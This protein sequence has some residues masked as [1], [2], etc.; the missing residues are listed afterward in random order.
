MGHGKP[1]RLAAHIRTLLHRREPPP[2]P[3][4]AERIRQALDMHD[5]GVRM[6]RQRMRREHPGASRREIDAMVREW[7]ASPPREDRFRFPPRGD[8]DDA[9]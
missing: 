3:P 5:T 1:A 7:L 4:E 6:Y 9:R 2:A 8:G